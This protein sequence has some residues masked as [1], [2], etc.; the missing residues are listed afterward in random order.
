MYFLCIFRNSNKLGK[1][2]LDKSF[3]IKV[4]I[5]DNLYKIPLFIL[6]IMQMQ[7]TSSIKKGLLKNI[8]KWV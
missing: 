5:Y 6:Y 2:L 8:N 3:L 1:G 4:Y 7:E